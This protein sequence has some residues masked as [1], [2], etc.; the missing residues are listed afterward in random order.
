MILDGKTVLVTGGTGSFGKEFLRFALKTDAAKIII[1]SR[2]ELKQSEMQKDPAYD[3]HRDRLRYFLGDVRDL[4]RLRRAF[5]GVDYVVHAAAL[6]QVPAIEY[7]P[8]EAKRTNIDGAANVIDAALDAGVGRVVALSTDKAT[9]PVNA[10]GASKLFAEKLFTA[11]NAYSGH[12]GTK[13]S[14]VRYGNIA[15]SRGSVIPIFRDLAAAGKPLPITDWDMTRFWFTLPGSVELVLYALEH[16]RGGETY[17][18][19][20]PGFRIVDLAEALAPNGERLTVGIRAGEKLHEAMIGPDEAHEF[21]FDGRYYVRN[22]AD[23]FPVDRGG[24]TSR[25]VRRL[26]VDEL[27]RLL[28]T[29]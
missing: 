17:V 16:M 29:V 4:A 8:L 22:A 13:F 12:A 7:N 23:G 3:D 11:A 10:Y 28:E 25:T 19:D 15:C 14:C 1:L 9:N 27:R 2:D 20:L 21:K 26:S 18:P 24:L 5:H 6:K